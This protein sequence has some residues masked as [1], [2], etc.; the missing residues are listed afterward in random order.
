[1]DSEKELNISFVACTSMF[2][3]RKKGILDGHKH[4]DEKKPSKH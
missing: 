1:M 2:R 4:F 3:W